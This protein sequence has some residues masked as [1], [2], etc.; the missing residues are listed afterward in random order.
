MKKIIDGIVNL[1]GNRYQ[2]INSWDNDNETN[3]NG[4]IA[5]GISGVE[6]LNHGGNTKDKKITIIVVGQ[7]LT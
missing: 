6:Y 4:C 3:L 7:I 5:V 1:L 2:V